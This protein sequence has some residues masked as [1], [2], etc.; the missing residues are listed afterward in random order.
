[1]LV[2]FSGCTEFFDS[3]EKTTLI[4]IQENK[5]VTEITYSGKL[6]EKGKGIISC[7]IEFQKLFPSA[8]AELEA[9]INDPDEEKRKIVKGKLDL[10]KEIEN[11][12]QCSLEKE[13][14]QGKFTVKFEVSRELVKKLAKLM[15]GEGFVLGDFNEEYFILKMRTQTKEYFS[16]EITKEN[17]KI[18]VEGEIVEVKPQGFAIKE[19]F[20]LFDETKSLDANFIEIEFQKKKPDEFPFLLVAASFIIIIALVFIIIIWKKR[21]PE[22][23]FT[24]S[25]EDIRQRMKKELINGLGTIEVNILSTKKLDNGYEAEIMIKTRKYHITFNKKMELKEYIKI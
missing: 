13:Q 8:K 6:S 14:D 5:I 1:M 3:A 22:E 24:H 19:G 18:K 23:M 10:L 9:N 11:S 2:L 21:K 15:P 17:L 4:D 16:S 25:E 12:I 20:I 7:D